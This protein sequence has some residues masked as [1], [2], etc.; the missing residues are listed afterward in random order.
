[1]NSDTTKLKEEAQ[2]FCKSI[3]KKTAS[4]VGDPKN[5]YFSIKELADDLNKYYSENSDSNNLDY[6]GVNKY[7]CIRKVLNNLLYTKFL[8]YD[9]F[10]DFRIVINK[11]PIIKGLVDYVEDDIDIF[12]YNTIGKS[13]YSTELHNLLSKVLSDANIRLCNKGPFVSGG[14]LRRAIL[15]QNLLDGDIDVVFKDKDQFEKTLKIVSNSDKF[16]FKKESPTNKTFIHKKSQAE[17]QLVNY[18]Y[19]DKAHEVI[20]DMDYRMCQFAFDGR[21]IT[22]N[23]YSL[24]DIAKGNLVVHNVTFGLNTVKRILKY[25]KQGFNIS[26]VELRKLLQTI[27]DNPSLLSYGDY[28]N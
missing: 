12:F 16:F 21:T 27:V 26:D 4:L 13:W 7:D 11:R 14:C 23:P 17:L 5:I 8:T 3:A 18:K 15:E 2:K 22:Y 25:N 20:D 9:Q 1:M 6:S 10:D 28:Y 19:F 24:Y